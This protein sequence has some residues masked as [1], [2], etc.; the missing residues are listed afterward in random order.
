MSVRLLTELTL[1][2]NRYVPMPIFFFGMMG[3]VWNI[4][5]FTR[6][7][8]I[9]NPCSIY[10]LGSSISNVNVLIFGSLARFLSD[11]FQIDFSS[12]NI[13]YCRFR[14]FILHTSMVLSSLQESIVIGLVLEMF[15]NVD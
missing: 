1:Q 13:G 5:V 8:L 11:G 14:Y 9:R 7:R 6:P 2:F 10:L 4:L 15:N 12:T 3:N